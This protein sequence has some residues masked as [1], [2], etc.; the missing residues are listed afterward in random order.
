M[1]LYET[2]ERN[3]WL[4]FTF[5]FF[6]R[7]YSPHYSHVIQ[8][9]KTNVLHVSSYFKYFTFRS[10][11]LRYLSLILQASPYVVA[12]QWPLPVWPAFPDKGAT[13][14]ANIAIL[15]STEHTVKCPNSW[16]YFFQNVISCVYWL[17]TWK[18]FAVVLRVHCSQ[19]RPSWLNLSP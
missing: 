19:E 7:C 14:T 16:N 10:L 13:N 15:P 5:Q 12:F 11:H 9:G 18:T 3:P 1:F 17:W 4:L 8:G 2:K 6:C